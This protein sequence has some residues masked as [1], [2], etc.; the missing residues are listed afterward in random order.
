MRRLWL[1][2]LLCACSGSSDNEVDGSVLGNSLSARDAL[3]FQH[4]GR[5]L[6]V[7]SDQDD[8]CRKLTRG[9]VSGE[10]H[11]LEL[12]LWDATAPGPT[13]LTEGTYVAGDSSA[14]LE[15]EVYLS[16]GRSCTAGTTR[17]RASSG[18]VILIHSGAN[19]PGERT[20]VAFRLNFGN[21]LLAGHADAVYCP[22]P[23]TGPIGCIDEPEPSP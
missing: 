21:D 23:A 10:L 8:T 6:V 20:Q 18:Q 19:E 17:F 4:A 11:L 12:Y 1:G 14:S 9:T 22:L 13:M 2:L 16:V 15:S 3:F 5:Q 7:I